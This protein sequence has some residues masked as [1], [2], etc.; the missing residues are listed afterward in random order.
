MT[1]S[2]NKLDSSQLLTA[3]QNAIKEERRLGIEVLKHLREIEARE[4]HLARGYPSLF[5]MCTTEF[6]Y[7]AGAAHR[8]IAAM[9]LIRDIPEVAHKIEN[10]KD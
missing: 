8:R 2:L 1:T 4:L 5:E 7:S 10:S 9:R 6:G 3:T